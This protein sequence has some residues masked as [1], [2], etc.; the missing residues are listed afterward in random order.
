MNKLLFLFSLIFLFSSD[1]ALAQTSKATAEKRRMEKYIELGS[2]DLDVLSSDI[3]KPA[4]NI[5]NSTS[6]GGEGLFISGSTNGAGIG[7]QSKLDNGNPNAITSYD[8]THTEGAV[9]YTYSSGGD[10]YIG[11]AAKAGSDGDAYV[12]GDVKMVINSD[13]NMMLGSVSTPLDTLHLQSTGSSPGIT[14]ENTSTTDG[15]LSEMTLKAGSQEG[16]IFITNQNNT[17]FGGAG[18]LNIAGMTGKSTRMYGSGTGNPVNIILENGRTTIDSVEV[19]FGGITTTASAANAYLDSGVANRLYRSTSSKRY[20]KNIK[21]IEIDT[22]KIYLLNPISFDSKV[23]SEKGIRHFGLIAEDVSK[24]LPSMVNYIPESEVFKNGSKDKLLP[25]GVQY[26]RL[27]VLMLPEIKKL[28]DENTIM[29]AWI[30]K[31]PDYP[32][33]LCGGE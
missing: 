21:P 12:A 3:T 2:G 30:C 27:A 5:S 32:T 4:I 26:S 20:K 13:G 22:S 25:D 19:R 7:F 31:Q 1:F 11:F 14:I 23:D 9:I 33:A 8:L 16:Y 17:S 29:K 24:I 6:G 28:R 10:S 15:N 18:V